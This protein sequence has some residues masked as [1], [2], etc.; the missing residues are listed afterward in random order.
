MTSHGYCDDDDFDT[1]ES[2]ARRR[3]SPAQIPVHMTQQ[4]TTKVAPS[5]D[6][7]TSFFA[8]EDA[9]DDWCD[10]T[11]LEPEKRG[12]ALRNRL[13][14]DAAVYKRLLDRD[15]LRDANEGRRGI[16]QPR[17]AQRAA[18]DDDE[19]EE[20]E[21]EE[22]EEENEPV[23]RLRSTTPSSGARLLGQE[24]QLKKDQSS[25]VCRLD[26]V[27]TWLKPVSLKQ[28]LAASEDAVADPGCLE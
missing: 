4:M 27:L 25:T 28:V 2:Y 23:G 18:Y 12:P 20:V 6:G 22:T 8:F 16:R 15:R 9:L 14:G 26:T 5:Y 11:E 17:Y 21:V 10:I 7:K 24:D 3:G 19:G 13:E 1:Y